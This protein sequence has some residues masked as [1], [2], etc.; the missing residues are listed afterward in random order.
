[1]KFN[2]TRHARLWHSAEAEFKYRKTEIVGEPFM[3]E[4]SH[5]A[6]R[7]RPQF[8]VK[9][10]E[11]FFLIQTHATAFPKNYRYVHS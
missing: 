4:H 5:P 8:C 6:Q 11:L 1:V 2:Y 3:N 7:R 9:Y 10:F